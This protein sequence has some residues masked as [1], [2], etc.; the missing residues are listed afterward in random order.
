MPNRAM[1][2]VSTKMRLTYEFANLIASFSER[3]TRSSE[4]IG[5]NAAETTPPITKS[6]IIIGSLLAISYA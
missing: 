6:N 2:A 5:M 1:V 4:N 3:L